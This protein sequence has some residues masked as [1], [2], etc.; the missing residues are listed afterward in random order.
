MKTTWR[1]LMENRIKKD[2]RFPRGSPQLGLLEVVLIMAG[3]EK[4][5]T[6]PEA[7]TMQMRMAINRTS[8]IPE[9]IFRRMASLGRPGGC[10]V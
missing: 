5:T 8:T 9:E 6:Y 1:Q 10:G 7:A 4:Q 2:G 3:S